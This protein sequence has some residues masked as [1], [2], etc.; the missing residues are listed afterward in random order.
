MAF[1]P[2]GSHDG[3]G[4]NG[5]GSF[6]PSKANLFAVV[7][8]IFHPDTN[9]GVSA[10]DANQELDVAAGGTG[11]VRPLART[12]E[13]NAVD[14]TDAALSTS[15]TGD[16]S[17]L[18]N[19]R[20]LTTWSLA[21]ILAR[22]LKAASNV[23]RGVVL[24]ARNQDVAATEND[25]TRIPTIAH[26]KTLIDR[27]APSSATDQTARDAAAAA[28]RKAD[29]A[30]PLAGGTL[31]GTL[32]LNGAPTSASHAATKKYVD[33]NAGGG[34]GA[35]APILIHAFTWSNS[36]NNPDDT[37]D[38]YGEHNYLIF[39]GWIGANANPDYPF[40]TAIRRANIPT[41]GSNMRLGTARG[42]TGG[43]SHLV[44]VTLNNAGRLR[45][46]PRDGSS[47]YGVVRVWGAT[48]PVL[49]GQP[50]TP[51]APADDFLFGTSDD[52]TPEADE[53]TIAAANGS[54]EIAAYNG[55]KH[56]LLARETDEAAITSVLRSD[57]VA[58]INQVGA[59]TQYASAVTVDG[60][61]YHV[62]V[63]NQALTQ[64]AA[65]TWTVR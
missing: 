65:V 35:P 48:Y 31:T 6:T 22:V 9:A 44:E 29:A 33:D 12:T 39:E 28:Q 14:S 4:G 32:T 13:V 18:D 47:D 43:V 53:L 27:L 58:Q 62:W 19:T 26:V 59:F 36:T 1:F 25:T 20:V 17:G 60:Q 23:Q 5:G 8:Q 15:I 24:L 57:D 21:G 45:L 51:A 40:T 41:S 7:K 54:A 63:S 30:L 2:A 61:D 37:D 34:A 56:I 52:S 50:A 49:G 16:Q 10:D 46:K 42:E 3:G 55:S 11:S 38:R 64:T